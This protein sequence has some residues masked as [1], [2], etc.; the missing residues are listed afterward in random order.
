MDEIELLSGIMTKTGDLIAGM[1]PGTEHGQSPCPDY[2]ASGMVRHLVGWVRW[3]G[4][5]AN[6]RAFD[7]DPSDVEVS[8][9]PAAQFRASADALVA[10]WREQGFDREVAMTGAPQPAESV[11]N[12]TLMEY[13]THGW[14]LA[15]ATGQPVPYTEAEAQEVLRRAEGTLPAQYRGGDMPFGE[16][17]PVPDDA[18]AI[19][20]LVGF[21]G[22]DPAAAR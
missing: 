17:V 11:F 8:D 14:D 20:R 10:G 16:I 18:P 2:D 15:V 19:D 9:D 6:G 7:G 3:F 22:R 21:M 4:A 13:L 5:A 1:P 12:M